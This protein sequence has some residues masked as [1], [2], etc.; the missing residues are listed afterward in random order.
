MIREDL[1]KIIRKAVTEA[2]IS[3]PDKINLEHPADEKWGD[4]STNVAMV[5]AKDLKQSPL[6]I[7]NKISYR[8]Q[9]LVP[10]LIIKHNEYSL[11]SVVETVKPGFINFRI[12]EKWLQDNVHNLSKTDYDYRVRE[13]GMDKTILV[14]YSQPNP[15]KPQHIGHARNNF[16]GNS[17]SRILRFLGFKVLET[18]YINDWGLHICKSML[19]YKKYGAGKKPDKKADHFVGDFYIMFETEVEKDPR[20]L[21]EAKELF[22]KLEAGDGETVKIWKKIVNWAYEGWEKTYNDQGI[23]FDLVQKQSD[24]VEKGKE[25]ANL[26]LKKGLAEK[27]ETGAIIAKLEKYGIP[28]KV[29]LRSD[30]TSIYST[31]DLE[32]AKESFEKYGLYKRLYVVDHRQDDYFRQIFKILEIFDFPWAGNLYHVSY[33]EVRLPEGAMSSRIG[34]VI[35]ADDVLERLLELEK[36]EVEKREELESSGQMKESEGKSAKFKKVQ[37]SENADKNEVI[38][39]VALAAFKY[40][41]LKVASKQDIVFD[42]SYVTKFEGDTGPYLQ[43]T[44][45]RAC[46]VLRKAGVKA[47]TGGGDLSYKPVA[48]EL[49]VMR[50][51]YKFSEVVIAAGEGF[52]PSLVCGYLFDLAQKFNSF[53]NVLSIINAKDA[54]AKNFRLSLTLAVSKVLKDGLFL[55][56]IDAPL[57]M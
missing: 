47:K 27:D 7:A 20:L 9:G 51:L 26:A 57:R 32:L 48:D 33:G 44:H 41:M 55:L 45:A 12:S 29:L 37:E 25:I 39:E 16:L 53:Y 40:P 11:F 3:C 31:Q 2:G 43:Y 13:I 14:E 23:K 10:T 28:D 56:G 22:R 34:L 4:Y 21:E 18:N 24:I 52:S 19:M 30:G 35:N 54:L 17:I 36:E 1:V 38:R 49:K 8:L 42:Y 6:E 50:A 15:N 46:S 5:I